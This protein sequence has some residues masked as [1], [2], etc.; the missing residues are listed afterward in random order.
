MFHLEAQY[1]QLVRGDGDQRGVDPQV[2]FEMVYGR[3][4]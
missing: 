2:A 1:T 3:T 4:E